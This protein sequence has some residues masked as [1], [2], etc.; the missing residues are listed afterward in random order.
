MATYKQAGVDI[1]VNSSELS[2]IGITEVFSKLPSLLKGM[3]IVKKALKNRKP[4]LLILIDFPDFNL[5]SA[6]HAKK[7]GI[8]VLY[9]ISPQIWAW[10]SGR[11]KKIGRLVNH[12]AVIFPF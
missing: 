10:R 8:P 2:V 1:L 12:I 5:H 7:L 6:S 11:V 4:D 3:S 9:Y